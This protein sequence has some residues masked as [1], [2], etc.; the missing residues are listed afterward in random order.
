[1]EIDF[2]IVIGLF[3]FGALIGIERNLNS[4]NKNIIK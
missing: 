1:M 3:T 2:I 4:I